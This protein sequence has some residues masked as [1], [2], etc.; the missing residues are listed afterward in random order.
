MWLGNFFRACMRVCVWH[1]VCPWLIHMGHDSF[2][3]AA[4]E[5]YVTCHLFQGQCVCVCA[6]VTWL[7][8]MS[9]VSCIRATRLIHMCCLSYQALAIRLL[10]QGLYECGTRVCDTCVWHMCVT[11]E[12][13]THRLMVAGHCVCE[14]LVY[15]L[16]AGHVCVKHLDTRD[17]HIHTCVWHD[18]IHTYI[19]E[20]WPH[21]YIHMCDIHT[22]VWFDHIHTYICATWPHTYLHVCDIYIHICLLQGLYVGVSRA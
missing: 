20:T 6:C 1:C 5:T 22:Y 4:E 16:V 15:T 3:C 18:H 17:T 12:S 7:I 10:L 19:C 21:T 11:C 13:C 2:I 14:T 8:Y 9:R